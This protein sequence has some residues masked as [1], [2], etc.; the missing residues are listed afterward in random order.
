MLKK[1]NENNILKLWDKLSQT[2]RR[3]LIRCKE[4][5]EIENC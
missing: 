1:G 5:F 4:V 3:V 2:G